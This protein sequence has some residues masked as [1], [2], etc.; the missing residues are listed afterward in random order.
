MGFTGK[1]AVGL[2]GGQ[3]GTVIDEDGQ[4]VHI[5]TLDGHLVSIPRDIVFTSSH[6]HITL[7]CES[8]SIYRY[9]SIH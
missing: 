1:S 2:S 4:A 9:A 5:R 7:I 6:S 3:V 8:S